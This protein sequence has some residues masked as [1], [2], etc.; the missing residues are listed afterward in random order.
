ME[1]RHG[2][3]LMLFSE[4]RGR[5]YRRKLFSSPV[6]SRSSPCSGA[7]FLYSHVLIQRQTSCICIQVLVSSRVS[8]PDVEAFFLLKVKKER[9]LIGR[10]VGRSVS[11]AVPTRANFPVSQSLSGPPC[12]SDGADPSEVLCHLNEDLVVFVPRY[13]F[14][15]GRDLRS[16][17]WTS[18]SPDIMTSVRRTKKS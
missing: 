16:L 5:A 18:S 8:H 14:I 2:E 3:F 11:Q 4:N 7:A 10:L 12:R 15:P 6:L 9:D 13:S 1:T 17:E